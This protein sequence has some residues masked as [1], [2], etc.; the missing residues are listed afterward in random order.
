[1]LV[2]VAFSFKLIF[3]FLKRKQKH[4]RNFILDKRTDSL[5]NSPEFSNLA[6]LILDFAQSNEI[7]YCP[8]PGNWGDALINLGTKQFLDFY[9][10]KH[11]EATRQQISDEFHDDTK[12]NEKVLIVGGG[13]GWCENWPTT[14]SFVEEMSNLFKNV[15]VLPTTFELPLLAQANNVIYFSRG[16][17][18][19]VPSTPHT[20]FCH[21]MAFFIDLEV[22]HQEPSLW[23]LIAFRGDKEKADESIS[24]PQQVDLSLLGNSYSSVEPFFEI[25]NRFNRVYTDRLHVAI[26]ASL[27]HKTTFLM[28]GNYGKSYDV[29]DSS[30]SENYPNTKY[31]P[32]KEARKAL[33]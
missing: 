27:L 21:D 31:L 14:R 29:W 10:I 23:R 25:V 1:M 32:W 12:L 22:P 6:K 11:T 5:R 17:L 7:L 16:R 28:S 9:G 20:I 24:H 2:Q 30:I 8:S 26:A 13:G 4:K 33:E 18:G 15:V 19:Q 3:N